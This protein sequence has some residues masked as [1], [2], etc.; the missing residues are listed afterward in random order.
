MIDYSQ[1]VLLGLRI[2]LREFHDH[3]SLVQ[4]TRHTEFQ[5]IRVSVH[6]SALA[7]MPWKVVGGFERVATRDRH[8]HLRTVRATR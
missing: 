7:W 8:L 5:Y 2:D 6:S 3:A 4:L 1:N